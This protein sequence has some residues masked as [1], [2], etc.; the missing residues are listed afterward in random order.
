ML[1]KT[2]SIFKDFTEQKF[3]DFPDTD[4]VF[5][6]PLFALPKTVLRETKIDH[7]DAEQKIKLGD[8]WK[9]KAGNNFRY[10]MVYEQRTVD[11]AHKLEDFLNII[12]DI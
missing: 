10:F 11:G 3:K 6:K 4:K 9:I 2:K 1:Q 7:L 12:R 5:I 8:L